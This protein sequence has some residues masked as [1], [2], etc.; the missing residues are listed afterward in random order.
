MITIRNR[1][2]SFIINENS[3]SNRTFFHAHQIVSFLVCFDPARAAQSSASFLQV[4]C[5]PNR[6]I[7]LLEFPATHSKQ[8]QLRFSNRHTSGCFQLHPYLR[9][10]VFIC[11]CNG[12]SLGAEAALKAKAANR[13]RQRLEIAATHSKQRPMPISNRTFLQSS[14]SLVRGTMRLVPDF[15]A[16]CLEFRFSSSHLFRGEA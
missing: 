9:S 12:S 10:S 7:P 11:G 13:T 4:P 5:L 6:H 15:R 2:K 16:S 8:R 3:I 1:R 14:C